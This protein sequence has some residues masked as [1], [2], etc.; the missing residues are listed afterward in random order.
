MVPAQVLN[1]ADFGAPQNRERIF[2][3][4]LNKKYLRIEAMQALCRENISDEYTPYPLKTHYNNKSHPVPMFGGKLKP[5]VTARTALRGLNEP[6]VEKADLAQM[7]LS[8]ARYYGKKRQGNVEIK[9]DE[10]APTI[11]AEH[12]GNIE[13]RRLFV[14]HGGNLLDEVNAG[15]LERRLTVRECAR[16]QTF[17]DDYEFIIRDSADDL[18]NVSASAS[19]K[20]I[21]NAVPPLLGY[22][23]AKRL[24]EV[25]ER[26]FIE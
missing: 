12:H 2:F 18:Y 14:E 5:Y 26:L 8:K 13:F 24:S 23:I 21:G 7:C 20:L 6:D 16:I 3:I 1:S 4:G 10:V 17:P 11:R 15:L 22:H 19:Y 25:W 9:L